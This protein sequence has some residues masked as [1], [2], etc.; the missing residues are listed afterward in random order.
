MQV[1][2]KGST[3]LQKWLDMTRDSYSKEELL[4]KQD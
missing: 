4:E 2:G 1:Q 3:E